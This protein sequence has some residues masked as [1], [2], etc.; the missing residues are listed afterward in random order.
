MS[1][2][3]RRRCVDHVHEELPV[4]ERR[5]CRV[6][7]KHRSTQRKVPRGADDEEALTADI[8]EL[9]R[10]YG[11]YGY[12]RVTALLRNAGWH[13][14]CKRVERIRRRERLKVPQR[15]HKRGRLWLNDGSCIR[16]RP[17]YPGHVW[18]YDFAEGRT[19]DGRKFRILAIIDEASRECMALLVA[20]R[21]RSADVLAILDDPFV[22]HGRPAQIGVQ[23]LYITPGS[24]WENG[25]CGSFNGSLRDELHNGE[26]FYSLAE[27]QILIEAWRRHY[28]TVRPHSSLGYRPPAPEAAL[29]PVPSSGSFS[30][31]LRPALAK[32]AIMH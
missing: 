29:W 24:P 14:N 30:L 17:E 1:P 27:A 28:N 6:L 18:A 7:G 21:I 23:T 4:S 10:Q 20:R 22:I 25:Y 9:A 15:Q 31:H 5:I 16:L 13:V 11:R 12:R 8:I 2:A 26:I 19:H 3:R 32:E